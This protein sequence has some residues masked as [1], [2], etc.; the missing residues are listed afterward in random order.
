MQKS[1]SLEKDFCKLLLLSFGGLARVVWST[2]TYP[3]NTTTIS[4]SFTGHSATIR[5]TGDLPAVST[6][7][8]HIRKSKASGCRSETK[9]TSDGQRVVMRNIGKGDELFFVNH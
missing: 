6:V 9:I 7:K 5:H 1:F 4:N 3:T 8:K 2:K